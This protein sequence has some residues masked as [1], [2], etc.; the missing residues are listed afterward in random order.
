MAEIQFKTCRCKII[1]QISVIHNPFE[2]KKKKKNGYLQYELTGWK[3]VIVYV[4]ARNKEI[5]WVNGQRVSILI[6][7]ARVY[8]EHSVCLTIYDVL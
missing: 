1:F 3:I 4:S 5:L 6:W 8:I 7:Q 2:K